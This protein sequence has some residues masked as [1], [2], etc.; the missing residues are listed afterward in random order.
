MKIMLTEIPDEGLNLEFERKEGWFEAIHPEVETYILN[1]SVSGNIRLRK[2]GNRVRVR[3]C[4]SGNAKTTCIRCLEDFTISFSYDFDSDFFP[5][6]DL[7]LIKAENIQ[8]KRDEMD[9]EFYSENKLDIDQII[10][11]NIILN[12]PLHPVCNDNCK[13]L[14]PI[15]GNNRNRVICNCKNN[16]ID[17]RWEK[18]RELRIKI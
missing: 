8:L 7:N 3:G 16:E 4:I 2:N 10:S 18:L 5:L 9:I 11:E 12:L 1:G 14:C 15:C 13:G 17:P 6:E